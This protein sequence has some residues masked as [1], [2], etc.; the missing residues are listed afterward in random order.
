MVRKGIG[1]NKIP[2]ADLSRVQ[3]QLS[4]NQVDGALDRESR[5]RATR[6][7]IRTRGRAVGNYPGNHHF[8]GGSPVGARQALA[9]KSRR[10][11]G[12]KVKISAQVHA[13]AHPHSQ[14]GPV[15]LHCGF[16]G[17]GVAAPVERDHVLLP[18][19]HPL[20]R[21]AQRQREVGDSHL[22]REHAA[23]LTETAPNVASQHANL[24]LRNVE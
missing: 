6:A 19:F 12:R 20:D 4:C 22:F 5:F 17:R 15:V 8:H 10:G 21:A 18:V 7:T 16:H 14:Y 2:A 24:R 3:V 13:N 9:G 11:W 1:L 23:L